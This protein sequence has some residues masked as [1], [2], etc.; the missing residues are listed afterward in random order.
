[1]DRVIWDGAELDAILGNGFS[2][3][4]PTRKSAIAEIPLGKNIDMTDR[5]QAVGYTNRQQTWPLHVVAGSRHELQSKINALTNL[6][7]G[8][9][10]DFQLSWDDATYH[11][12]ASV[13]GVTHHGRGHA[14]T[15]TVQ[16]DCEPWRNL[17]TV[18]HEVNS[19]G[20]GFV[21]FAGPKRSAK[22]VFDLSTESVVVWNGDELTLPAGRMSVSDWWTERRNTFMAASTETAEIHT[23]DT[24]DGKQFENMKTQ[25]IAD[26]QTW[27]V[28]FRSSDESVPASVSIEWEEL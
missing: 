8:E 11:G 5:V 27:G 3:T 12:R 16:V 6:L 4:P 19:A 2:D 1:M 20:G 13:T 9:S 14:G 25:T 24:F 28:C 7:D 17:G 18:T 22:P 26:M 15:V 21:E 10:A 23:N